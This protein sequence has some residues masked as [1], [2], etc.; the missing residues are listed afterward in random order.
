MPADVVP[1]NFR[2]GARYAWTAL[3]EGAREDERPALLESAD[4]LFEFIDR[5][6][7]LFSDTYEST[8]PP[9]VV[10][11]EERRALGL[12]ARVCS[13][14]A[15]VGEDYQLAERLGFELRAP[16]RPFVLSAPSR[17]VQH[18]A[19][20]AGRL[21]AERVLATSEGRRVAGVAPVRL[22]WRDLE[23]GPL[24]AMA[25]GEATPRERL[26][27]ALDDLRTVVDL[28][29][30]HGHSGTVNIDDYLPELLLQRSPR[31]AARLR[32]RVYGKLAESDPELARTLDTLIEH[33]FDR[34]ATAAALPVHRN[35]LS[36]RINRIRAVTGL[37]ID[38]ADGHGA[39]WLAW[40]D[41]N[42]SA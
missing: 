16:Y 22:R 19:T 29:L 2:H 36:N 28:A 26:S 32:A 41:R 7:Q 9:A 8:R 14:A 5:V 15:L 4:L 6:S 34:G 24:A 18:H 39:V 13:D 37:D 21:R 12:L 17:S 25:Q 10:S 1:A 31:L 40:L 35:T 27:E 30:A 20:L 33:D 11:D 3:L 23:L 38:R 42:G